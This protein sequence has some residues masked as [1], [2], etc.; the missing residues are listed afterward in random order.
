MNDQTRKE[1]LLEAG[2]NVLDQF[3]TAIEL[4]TQIYGRRNGIS[5]LPPIKPKRSYD[6]YSEEIQEE[7]NK[8]TSSEITEK[9]KR[10]LWL[11]LPVQKKKKY[12]DQYMKEL[13]YY[14]RELLKYKEYKQKIDVRKRK[15][16]ETTIKTCPSKRQK[17]SCINES[18]N[19]S[20]NESNEESDNESD[21][22]GDEESDSES[23]NESD[24]E[25]DEESN[26]E[27]NEE[28]IEES[29]EESEEENVDKSVDEISVGTED[30]NITN[31]GVT[32]YTEN[33][34]SM[35]RG[36]FDFSSPGPFTN[37]RDTPQNS[38]LEYL[39]N[40]TRENL[41]NSFQDDASTTIEGDLP[42]VI[43]DNDI[44]IKQEYRPMSFLDIEPVQTNNI[45]TETYKPSQC[46][47]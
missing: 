24:E 11:G 5:N 31:Y 43:Q 19:E 15:N 47:H 10:E 45:K 33:I 44:P 30:V 38:L 4:F 12:E 34:R 40:D 20:D 32:P 16:P 28:S 35:L 41:P 27:S 29:N 37:S 26:E 2:T 23:N 25:S 3:G 17:K 42:E 39:P 1:K 46:G 6:L 9:L 22:E 8:L 14:R 36:F 13:H 18:D 7:L 21:E